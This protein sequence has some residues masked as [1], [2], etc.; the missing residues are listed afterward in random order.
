LVPTTDSWGLDESVF[1]TGTIAPNIG[2]GLEASFTVMN[3][4]TEPDEEIEDPY[5][6]QWYRVDPN[7][8]EQEDM[9][10]GATTLTYTTTSVD[11]RYQMFIKATGNGNFQ[12][13]LANS[14]PRM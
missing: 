8:W 7:N 3:R 11:R 5:T 9:V 2:F 12:G 1:L 13:G 10:T 6:Y 4:T 14:T